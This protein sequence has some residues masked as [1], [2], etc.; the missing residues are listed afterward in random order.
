MAMTLGQM[1][2]GEAGKVVGFDK[3]NRAYRQKLLAMGL[4][5]GTEFTVVRYAPLGDPVEIRVRGFALSLRKAEA[6][7]LLVERSV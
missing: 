2:V 5:P 6:N 3:S 4:T 7:A 1:A